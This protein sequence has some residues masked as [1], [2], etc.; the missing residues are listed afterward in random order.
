MID[1]NIVVRSAYLTPCYVEKIAFPS[2][3]GILFAKIKCVKQ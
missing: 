3:L 2:N 1:L